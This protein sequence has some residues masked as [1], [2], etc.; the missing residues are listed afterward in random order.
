MVTKLKVKTT[1]ETVRFS[2]EISKTDYDLLQAQK[3]EIKEKGFPLVYDWERIIKR[4]IN[5]MKK[6]IAIENG[7]T[8]VPKK[9][10]N[11]K[12][13]GGEYPLNSTLTK[14]QKPKT[15][16]PKGRNT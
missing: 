12:G 5:L 13:G 15:K 16:K 9:R 6:A 2:I 1:P 10:A 8:P 14:K 7:E 11:K 3:A 4:E